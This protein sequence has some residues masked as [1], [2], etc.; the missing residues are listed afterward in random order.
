MYTRVATTD[1]LPT[2]TPASASSASSAAPNL[3]TREYP[4]LASYGLDVPRRIPGAA[5]LSRI[6]LVQ[7]PG[8]PRPAPPAA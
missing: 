4:D 1:W 2:P 6:R 3:T 5:T 8:P 7:S